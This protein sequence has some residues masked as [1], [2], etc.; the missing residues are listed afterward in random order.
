[1]ITYR[2]TLDVARPIAGYLAQ[3][4]TDHRITLRTPRG[5]RALTVWAHAVLVLRWFRD[6]TPVHRLATDAGISIAT[7]YRY[8]HEGI[9]VL[10]AQAPD[11]NDILAERLA[12]GDTH[13][14]L[15]GTA[16]R[17]TRVAGKVLKTRGTGQPVHRWYSG[18]HRTFAGNIQFLATA[19]GHPLWCSDVLPGGTHNDLAAA[20]THGLVGALCAAAAH[21]LKTLADKAYHAAGIGIL[22]PVKGLPGT[23]PLHGLPLTPDEQTYNKLHTTIRCLGERAAAL[24]KTRWRTLHRVTLSPNRIGDII[25]AALV[26]THLEHEGRH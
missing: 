19:D 4:L 22:T 8:L 20:R 16:I 15:D 10:A 2:A 13:L 17:T 14:I 5:R 23:H 12:A 21:G 9:T 24:L 11:L 7:G 3:L 1:M 26:L 18:K 6:A 25:R